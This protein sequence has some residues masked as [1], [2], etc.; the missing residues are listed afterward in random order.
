MKKSRIFLAALVTA[1]VFTACDKYTDESNTFPHGDITYDYSIQVIPVG[2]LKSIEGLEGATVTIQANNK[3]Q[4]VT[5]NKDGIAIF[6]KVKPG[7]ISGYVENQGY[8]N[9]NFTATLTD[10]DYINN[11]I[12]RNAASTVYAI[13]ENAAITGRVYGDFDLDGVSD[14]NDN[15][16]IKAGL[17]VSLFFTPNNYPFGAGDGQLSTVNF[18]HVAYTTTTNASGNFTF[19][20][21]PSTLNGYISARILV[22]DYEITKN[23]VKYIFTLNPVNVNTNPGFTTNIGDIQ[24]NP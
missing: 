10:F 4:T 19:E 7:F 12:N 13:K 5:V 22:E 11:K 20:N 23:N 6:K 24:M 16:D 8:L 18:D 2:D 9:T 1:S 14:P 3:T 21:I 15:N 17:K